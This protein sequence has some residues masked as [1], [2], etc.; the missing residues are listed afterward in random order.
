MLSK[1]YLI[2][3]NIQISSEEVELN[4]SNLFILNVLEYVN[5][6]EKSVEKQMK[7]GVELLSKKSI[8]IIFKYTYDEN[9]K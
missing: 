1:T 6:T 8:L 9:E 3:R 2:F 4:I 5:N 7:K